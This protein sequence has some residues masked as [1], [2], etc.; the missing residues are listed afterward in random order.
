MGR[1]EVGLEAEAGLRAGAKGHSKVVLHLH[2]AGTQK[3]GGGSQGWGIV[4][5]C[6]SSH[7]GSPLPR[8]LPC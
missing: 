2:Q 8:S 4:C 5:S 3:A 6:S 1:A 7:S